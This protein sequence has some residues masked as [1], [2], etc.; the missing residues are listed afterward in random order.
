MF[1]FFLIALLPYHFH[2]QYNKTDFTLLLRMLS[3]EHLDI[4][5]NFQI[6]FNKTKA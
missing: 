4:I 6:R 2:N 1:E 5:L 3:L